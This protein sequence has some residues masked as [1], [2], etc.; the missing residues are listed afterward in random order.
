MANLYFEKA[1]EMTTIRPD[2]LTVIKEAN[3]VLKVMLPLVRDNGEIEFIPAY[4]AQHKHH[5]L[6]TKGGTRYA[7]EVDVEECEAL[8]LLMSIKCCVVDLPY[9]GAKGGIKINP[10]N[11]S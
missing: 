7:P 5:Y 11:Y 3:A 10:K 9:G 1:S 6:P 8:A 4:R 2:L